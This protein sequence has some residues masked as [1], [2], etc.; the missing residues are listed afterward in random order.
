MKRRLAIIV[1]ALVV[2]GAAVVSTGAAPFFVYPIQISL[3]AGAARSFLLTLNA[4]PGAVTTEENAAFKSAAATFPLPT[5]AVPGVAIE[6]WPS[7][8]KT[9]TSERYSDL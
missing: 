8:N 9:L 4:P 2:L 6:D 7:Y 5:G 1:I 3:L